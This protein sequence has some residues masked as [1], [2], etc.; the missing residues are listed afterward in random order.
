MSRVT[1]G[2]GEMT[3]SAVAKECAHTMT[4]QMEDAISQKKKSVN[5]SLLCLS[6]QI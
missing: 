4:N 6:H 1:T 3:L 5:I 2:S